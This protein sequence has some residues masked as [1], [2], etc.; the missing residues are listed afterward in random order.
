VN[1]CDFSCLAA[2]LLC[3]SRVGDK[4][5]TSVTAAAA[6]TCTAVTATTALVA[7]QT[8]LSRTRLN[9]Q[10]SQQLMLLLEVALHCSQ[11]ENS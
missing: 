6:A 2:A 8:V 10:V 9:Q 7:S 1:W 3:L 5:M 4:S 11:I